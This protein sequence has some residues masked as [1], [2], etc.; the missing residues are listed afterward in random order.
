MICVSIA[1]CTPEACLKALVGIK[2]A[3]IRLETITGID[4]AAV[5][6][7]FG[8][9]ARLVATCRP[10]K[11]PEE[12]R[13][14]L[15]LAAIGAGA[16]FVDVEFDAADAYKQ[17][18][19]E[20]ANAAGCD[21][22]VSFHDHEKTPVREELEQIIS[23][24]FDSG[25]DVAKIACKANCREDAARLLGL[26]GKERRLIVAGMGNEGKIVRIVAPLLGSEIAYVAQGRGK[27]TAS[28]QMTA[29]EL[30]RKMKEISDD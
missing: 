23:W 6:W 14:K 7:I 13:K 3:E 17:E 30:E 29:D 18:I 12:R 8:S 27:E 20:K 11:L 24:C 10:G 19:V 1:N 21:V 26:L 28:G 2:A 15:L 25:A 5:K 22:I 9:K 16:A 4:E